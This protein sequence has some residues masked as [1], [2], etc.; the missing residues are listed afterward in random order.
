M[1]LKISLFF[2]LAVSSLAAQAQ[3][4]LP[5][6]G[7]QAMSCNI[8]IPTGDL[9]KFDSGTIPSEDCRIV[10][11]LPPVTGAINF[12]SVTEFWDTKLCSLIDNL[13][14]NILNHQKAIATGNLSPEQI[15]KISS[16]VAAA[17]QSIDTLANGNTVAATVAGSVHLRWS[18]LVNAYKELNPNIDVRRMPII[19]G[20]FSTRVQEVDEFGLQGVAG[21][22]VRMSVYGLGLPN[23]ND[24]DGINNM[25]FP[26][27]LKKLTKEKGS[28]NVLMGEGMGF[29]MQLNLKGACAFQAN[30]RYAL[31]GTYTYF[32]PVQT[33]SLYRVVP[34]SILLKAD[35]LKAINARGTNV[36]TTEELYEKVKDSNS[37]TVELNE[38]IFDGQAEAARLEKD[39][40]EDLIKLVLSDVL[41]VV[42]TNISSVLDSAK[43][44]AE[45]DRSRETC[46]KKWYGHNKCHTH[47]YKVTV[48]K[49]KWEAVDK[50]LQELVTTANKGAQAVTYKTFNMVGTSA[51]LPTQMRGKNGK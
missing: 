16:E 23:E 28:V 3:T 6:L 50:M 48:T 22:V 13:Y 26:D 35:I 39:Y 14:E 12:N 32:Y 51:M 15:Q 38:G 24:Y 41:S 40:K 7:P 17:N 45:E 11:V 1:R 44:Q 43:Y 4:T 18:R 8:K 27:Y 20:V 37:V 2:I 33:K 25:P 9:E 19:A 36:I 5:Y 31:A 34:N 47:Y 46:K 30:S 49:I 42:S 29:D 21:G 10:Y